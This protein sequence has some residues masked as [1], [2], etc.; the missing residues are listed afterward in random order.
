MPTSCH[1]N[2][3]KPNGFRVNGRVEGRDGGCAETD[4]LTLYLCI[5]RFDCREC[6][7]LRLVR[8]SSH[9]RLRQQHEYPHPELFR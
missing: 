8:P 3:A 9:F 7:R 2:A 1:L 6:R 5:E 4:A